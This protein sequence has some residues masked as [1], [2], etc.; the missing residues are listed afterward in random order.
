MNDDEYRWFLRENGVKP[1]DKI[2]QPKIVKELPR[3]VWRIVVMIGFWAIH[4]VW[5]AATGPD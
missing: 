5:V 3:L 1:P 4:Y 2:D